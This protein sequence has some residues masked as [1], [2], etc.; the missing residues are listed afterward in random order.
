[1]LLLYLVHMVL[2]IE[3]FMKGIQGTVVCVPQKL[4]GQYKSNYQ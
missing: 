3:V 4:Y 2:F 1:M